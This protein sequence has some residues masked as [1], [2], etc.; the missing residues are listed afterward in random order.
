MYFY[1]FGALGYFSHLGHQCRRD[2]IALSQEGS[3]I[4]LIELDRQ[5]V[6]VHHCEARDFNLVRVSFWSE[7]LIKGE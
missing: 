4:Q 2:R 5:E 1:L 7:W 3:P 6:K